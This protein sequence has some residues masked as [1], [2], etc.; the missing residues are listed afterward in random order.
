VL[1]RT[2]GNE[3]PW[4]GVEPRMTTTKLPSRLLA[5]LTITTAVGALAAGPAV[6]SPGAGCHRATAELQRRLVQLHYVLGRADGCDGPATRAAVVAFQKAQ[7][8]TAD[9]VAGPAT[10]R[11]MRSPIRPVARSRQ[12]GEHIEI[13]RARQLLLRVRDGRVTQI[14]AATTGMSGHTTPAGRFRIATQQRQSWSHEYRV[15][16]HWASYFDTRRGLAIHAG[17]IQPGPA[18]HG[19]VRV[20]AVFARRLYEAM[21][22]GTAVIIR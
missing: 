10:R 13:S 22:P 16:M 4:S 12:R 21:R 7:G 1:S 18:S 14:F 11:A 15:W 17:E 8:L 5:L 9:G 20:P 6:A 3:S 2:H 19:C